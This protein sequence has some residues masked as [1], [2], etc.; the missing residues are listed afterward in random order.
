MRDQ[1]LMW[2]EQKVFGF[3]YEGDVVRGTIIGNHGPETLDREALIRDYGEEV[4]REYT[5]VGNT[6]STVN[7]RDK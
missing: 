4:I 6:S 2:K 3:D 7:Y 1:L 5:K